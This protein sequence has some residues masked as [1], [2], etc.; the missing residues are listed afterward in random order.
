MIYFPWSESSERGWV[1]LSWHCFDESL[2]MI[3]REWGERAKREELEMP[4]LM[5]H[6]ESSTYI[7]LIHFVS[8]N[9]AVF[10]R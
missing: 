2:S 6:A 5:F 4:A 3:Q 10:D 8:L 9:V 1:R 7:L